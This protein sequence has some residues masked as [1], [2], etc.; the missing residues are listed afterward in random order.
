MQELSFMA[1]GTS[2]TT[3]YAYT[4]IPK[5]LVSDLQTLR[6]NI[7]GK[8]VGFT[9]ESQDDVWILSCVYSQSEHV[10]TV[11]LPNMEIL[12][13]QKTPWIPIATIAIAV[14]I[15]AIALTVAIRRRRRTAATVAS[16]LKEKRPAY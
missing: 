8:P 4:C 9:S 11:Q 5:T 15:A 7:D 2:G 1:N 3:G 14:L 6:L 10:F 13:P 12:G 16:I